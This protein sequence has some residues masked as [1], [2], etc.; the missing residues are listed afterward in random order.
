MS[1]RH[2]GG[3]VAYRLEG[4]PSCLSG[5]RELHVGHPCT[6]RIRGPAGVAQ[7]GYSNRITA[8]PGEMRKAQHPCR[9]FANGDLPPFLIT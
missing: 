1:L 7:R 3:C 2:P 6:Q 5:V 9:I 4:A 8:S